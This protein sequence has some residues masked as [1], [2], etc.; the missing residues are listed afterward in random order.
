MY[1]NLK[2]EHAF[3]CFL[4]DPHE[5]PGDKGH[6]YF[7]CSEHPARAGQNMDEYLMNP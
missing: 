7:V 5:V 1:H 4:A 6:L 2:P 3:L